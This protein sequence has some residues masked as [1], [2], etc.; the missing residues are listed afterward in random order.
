MNALQQ[1]DAEFS[2]GELK[3]K[4]NNDGKGIM[5]RGTFAGTFADFKRME[6]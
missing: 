4:I 1:F 3:E 5:K 2:T 6:K